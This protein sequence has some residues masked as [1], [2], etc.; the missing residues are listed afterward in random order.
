MTPHTCF[1]APFDTSVE[2]CDES[3][4][5]YIRVAVLYRGSVGGAA[6]LV[7]KNHEVEARSGEE[8]RRHRGTIEQWLFRG[9][10]GVH[11]TFWLCTVPR[12]VL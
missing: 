6:L 7:D 10:T 5:S 2:R 8:H 12:V 11:N 3:L 4:G 9:S 1:F